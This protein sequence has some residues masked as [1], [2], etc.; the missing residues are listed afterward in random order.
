[1]ALKFGNIFGDNG[2]SIKAPTPATDPIIRGADGFPV[3]GGGWTAEQW[4]DYF[5]RLRDP[6]ITPEERQQIYQTNPEA[7]QAIHSAGIQGPQAAASSLYQYG[8]DPNFATNASNDA[9]QRAAAQQG[10]AAPQADFTRSQ[11]DLAA[12]R[13]AL[14]AGAGRLGQAYQ[15][16]EQQQGLASQ[17]G[18]VIAGKAPSVAQLAMQRASADA[19]NR[20]LA[21]A[22]GVGGAGAT[23]ALINAQ[24][25][26]A[27]GQGKL[28]QDLGVQRAAEIAQARGQLGDVLT[29]IRGQTGAEAGMYGNLAGQ[30]TNIGQVTGQQQLGNAALQSQ[31]NQLNQQG[32]QYYYGQ[33]ADWIKGQAGL[34]AQQATNWNNFYLGK[35]SNAN[36]ANI[37]QQQH[38]DAVTGA[39]ISG[40]GTV[41]AGILTGVTG[42]AAA[43]AL[44]ASAANTAG[45]IKKAAGNDGYGNPQGGYPGS[46]IRGKTAIAPAGGD[47]SQAYRGIA[48]ANEAASRIRGTEVTSPFAPTSA[49]SYFYKNPAAPGAEP[50]QHYGPM[51]HELEQ[52]PAGASVVRTMPDG[53]KGIDTGRLA[54]LN[55]SETGQLRRE[56]DA[57]KGSTGKTAKKIR[58]TNV[59]YPSLDVPTARYEDL[60][61]ENNRKEAMLRQ[62]TSMP[63][64]RPSV[65]AAQFAG[66]GTPGGYTQGQYL[67][68][69]GLTRGGIPTPKL[70]APGYGY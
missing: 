9:M 2:V 46:D 49:S 65:S 18:D 30:A 26:N 7:Q 12:G 48:R 58:E 34:N 66:Y 52:T 25:I 36:Q 28:V 22:A 1:M 57:L 64:A 37:A 24:N 17:L 70:L 38:N 67:E 21:S 32:E 29:G 44:A 54:L 61:S 19:A 8:G 59:T 5:K 4:A 47:I 11:G 60:K 6:N 69:E 63:V 33:G 14:L 15:V 39:I 53:R 50:G 42:G 41:G 62:L 43:P 13:G 27:V 68:N 16:G 56:V 31:Q 3:S 55:A 10:R 20:N 40:A 45:Q 23:A 35:E 51:A